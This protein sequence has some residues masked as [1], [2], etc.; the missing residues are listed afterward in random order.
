MAGRCRLNDEYHSRRHSD[1]GEAA[2]GGLPGDHAHVS[3]TS[4]RGTNSAIDRLYQVSRAGRGESETMSV[5][6][7]EVPIESRV[8]YLNANYG[9]RSWLLTTDH[10]RI[11][12]LYL[13]SITFMFFIGGAAAVLIRLAPGGTAG[14][15]GA[16]GNLQQAVHHAR[17][18][19]DFLFPDS[20]DPGGPGKFPGSDD[21][22]GARPGVPAAE[23][24][25]LVRLCCRGAA[26]P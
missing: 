17:R 21:D 18:G 2:G 23:S 5:T 11:A 16:A 25:E 8:H 4:K 1:A 9:I 15:A 12:L 10:K 20:G 3:R 26:S 6:V 7:A 19:D 14:R 24:A 13:A 22:R